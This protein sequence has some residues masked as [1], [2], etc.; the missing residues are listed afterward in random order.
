MTETDWTPPELLKMAG[1]YWS[2]CTLHAGVEL[3]LFTLLSETPA[4]A[5]DLST[6]S[7]LSE[8]GLTMLLDALAA[9]DLL[10]KEDGVYFTTPFSSEFLSKTSVKY[11]GHIISHHHH[12]VEGWSRLDESVLSGEPIRNRL[13]HEPSEAERESFLMG[14][15]NVAM[16]MAPIIVPQIDLTGRKHLLDLGGGPGTYAIHFCMQNPEMKATI[17]D[18]PTTRQFAKQTVSRFSMQKRIDFQSGDFQDD[19]I[20]GH[21]DVAWLSHVLHGEGEVGC[22]NMLQKTVSALDPEGLLL[23]QEFILEDDRAKPVFPALFSLNML[24]GTPAGKAYSESEIVLLL[25]K[26]GLEC[27]ERLPIDLPNGAGVICGRRPG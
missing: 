12:L 25:Q 8:R 7:G 17:F 13:S 20:V 24:L 15:F 1:S 9:L 18:L 10:Q 6:R 2:A 19:T 21:Y 23:V 5:T 14:M 26:A 3:D 27:V 4:T 16:Q 11:M 22:S